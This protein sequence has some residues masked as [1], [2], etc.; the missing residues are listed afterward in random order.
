VVDLGRV[1]RVTNMPADQPVKSLPAVVIEVFPEHT[2]AY[3]RRPGG[4]VKVFPF[5][6]GH[7]FARLGVRT[8][9]VK[10]ETRLHAGGLRTLA[11]ALL[12]RADL[13]DPSGARPADG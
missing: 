5:Q 7:S 12:A 13:L 8:G 4:A 10:A 6:H 2:D 9:G 3:E 1:E 11:A